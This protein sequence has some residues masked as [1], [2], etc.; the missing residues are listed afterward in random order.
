MN[1]LTLTTI[2]SFCV[3]NNYNP[4]AIFY[5]YND[6]G[7][8]KVT[9]LKNADNILLYIPEKYKLDYRRARMPQIELRD[10][11]KSLEKENEN[12]EEN[13]RNNIENNSAAL[14]NPITDNDNYIS[15]RYDRK[16]SLLNSDKSDVEI[17]LSK[18]VN[19]LKYCFQNLQKWG[20]FILKNHKA[21]IY[22][23][24]NTNHFTLHKCEE[25]H[26][27]TLYLVVHIQYFFDKVDN[28]NQEH[29]HINTEIERLLFRNQ[30]QYFD[31][32]EKTIKILHQYDQHVSY[33]KTYQSSLVSQLNK[34][35]ELLMKSNVIEN[36]KTIELMNVK[37][38][39]KLGGARETDKLKRE[40]QRD[41]IKK[42]L[43][44]IKET[45]HQIVGAINTLSDIKNDLMISI[46]YV[47]YE[48]TQLLEKLEKMYGMIT[49]KLQMLQKI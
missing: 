41:R 10:S 11:L 30:N 22:F 26:H 38:M 46:D 31:N 13:E 49:C 44:N 27:M 47:F 34:Y 12:N 48:N 21:C 42:S 5:K 3:D 24:D 43:E 37:E 19:K 23:A 14:Y 2:Q 1:S 17:V 40:N 39:L 36:E 8:L 32:I 15:Q 45:K 35:K 9:C 7:L 25:F 28:I 6:F 18:E 16:M 20:F 4:S 29:E 33:L